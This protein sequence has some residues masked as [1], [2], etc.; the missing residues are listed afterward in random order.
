MAVEAARQ[1]SSGI[2]KV[3]RKGSYLKQAMNFTL[4]KT[5]VFKN[6]ILKKARENVNFA[7]TLFS[8]IDCFH[9][10]AFSVKDHEGFSVF[11]VQVNLQK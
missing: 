5:P 7:G 4:T 3:D 11:G 6:V 2:L 8:S 10:G 1:L 9:F